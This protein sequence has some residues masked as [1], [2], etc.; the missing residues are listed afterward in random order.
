MV[1]MHGS[2][3]AVDGNQV[4]NGRTLLRLGCSGADD[5]GFGSR[6]KS[7]YF[8][9]KTIFRVKL[10]H[11]LNAENTVFER[12]KEFHVRDS[13]YIYDE[14]NHHIYEKVFADLGRKHGYRKRETKKFHTY[15]LRTRN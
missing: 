11:Q 3:Y 9:P 6:Y 12:L 2:I 5:K 15:N 14:S 7:C 8:A 13:F 4:D 10:R 1:K